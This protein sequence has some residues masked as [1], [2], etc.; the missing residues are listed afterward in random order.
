[1]EPFAIVALAASAGGLNAIST[2]LA[3]LRADFPA[4]LVVVQ[5]LDRRHPSL[6]AEILSR[7]TVLA[8]RQAAH[9]EHIRSGIAYI[10]PPD[11]HLLVEPDGTLLLTRTKLV[12]FVRPSAD[13]LFESVAG[14]FGERAIGVVLSGTGTD[15]ALGAKAMR[16]T[17]G[18]LIVQDEASAE[19]AGMPH[20]AR[21]YA[22]LVLPLGEIAPAL[23]RLVA[24]RA[25]A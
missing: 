24:S 5:H 15:G 1:M 12:H 21:A 3:G 23:E 6:M 22:D 17:G 19:H 16:E 20:A 25:A 9:G 10:A 8:V 14:S 13:L 18:K 11:H 7:R 4:P 2:V